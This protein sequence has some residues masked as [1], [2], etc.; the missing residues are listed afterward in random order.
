MAVDVG[1]RKSKRDCAEASKRWPVYQFSANSLSS[2]AESVY[3]LTDTQ[4]SY[5]QQLKHISCWNF[6]PFFATAWKNISTTALSPDTKTFVNLANGGSDLENLEVTLSFVAM[7]SAF[8]LYVPAGG[9]SLPA[10]WKY[11][12]SV[13]DSNYGEGSLLSQGVNWARTKC[14]VIIFLLWGYEDLVS[15]IWR[16]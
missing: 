11:P 3:I 16:R 13:S 14:S 4:I 15:H 12:L 10:T 8:D 6:H 1:K 5:K 7:T 9:L 2:A